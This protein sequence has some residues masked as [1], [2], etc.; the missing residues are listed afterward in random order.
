IAGLKHATVPAARIAIQTRLAEISDRI[1]I[2]GVNPGASYGYHPSE[3]IRD[4]RESLFEQRQAGLLLRMDSKRPREIQEA[5]REYANYSLMD[6]ATEFL[7]ERG[8]R[9]R[10]LSRSEI[11][12]QALQGSAEYLRGML[13]TSDL[14]G[15]LTSTGQRELLMAY[16]AAGPGMKILCRPS[17]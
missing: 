2:S 14:P 4:H 5:G 16:Q 17:T 6:F 10:N 8:I 12:K 9:T 1:H 11:A 15:L 3:I 13:T 7:Q